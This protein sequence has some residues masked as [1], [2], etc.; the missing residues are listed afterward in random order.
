MSGTSPASESKVTIHSAPP[1]A[2]VTFRDTVT[3]EIV[4]KFS[5]SA[6]TSAAVALTGM[7]IVSSPLKDK[8]KLPESSLVPAKRREMLTPDHAEGS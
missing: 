3:T 5:S 4:S 6:F 1:K 2:S 7:G 8:V